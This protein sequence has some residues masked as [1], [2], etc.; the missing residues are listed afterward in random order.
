M[1]KYTKNKYTNKNY[2]QILTVLNTLLSFLHLSRLCRRTI[3]FVCAYTFSW[4]SA[5]QVFIMVLDNIKL[6]EKN[7]DSG[8][9]RRTRKT[10]VPFQ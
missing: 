6:P 1:N 3:G 5:S 2:P 10:K 8:Q 7:N 9:L 4:R